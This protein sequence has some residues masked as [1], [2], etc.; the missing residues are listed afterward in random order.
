MNCSK[1]LILN[2]MIDVALCFGKAPNILAYPFVCPFEIHMDYMIQD[3][4]T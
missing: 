3:E 4:S 1:S 2:D